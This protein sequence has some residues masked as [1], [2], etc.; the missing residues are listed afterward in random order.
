M[1]YSK[2]CSNC[3][4]LDDNY[5]TNVTQFL[6]LFG[7]ALFECLIV[8]SMLSVFLINRHNSLRL[9]KRIVWRACMIKE[10]VVVRDEL[11]CL[12]SYNMNFISPNMA[13][14]CNIESKVCSRDFLSM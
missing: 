11:C 10:L 4:L 13:A 14:Q 12:S 9:I 2:T 7:S 3:F 8:I 6:M 5:G 1:H